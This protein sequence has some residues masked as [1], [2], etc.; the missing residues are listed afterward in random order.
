MW[1][2]CGCSGVSTRG[3]VTVAEVVTLLTAVVV[4]ATAVVTWRTRKQVKEV[5]VM[6]NSQREHMVARL[7]QLAAALVES[8]TAVPPVPPQ[9]EET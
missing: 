5:H 4:L 1:C 7:D 2:C 9:R 3:A 6:V 8:G